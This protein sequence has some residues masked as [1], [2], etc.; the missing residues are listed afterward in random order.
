MKKKLAL[1]CCLLFAAVTLSSCA[2]MALMGVDLPGNDAM[3]AGLSN[4]GTPSGAGG[5]A[6]GGSG[7]TVTISR[8]EYDR[9]MKLQTVLDVMDI[10][11]TYYYEDVDEQAMIDGAAAGALAG[12]G[13]P[14]TFYYTAEEYA[15]LW[16]D[17]EGEYA[18][19]G[20]QITT[21]YVTNLCTISRVFAG[22]PAEKA[23]VQRND[24][25]YKVGDLFVNSET[26]DEA[27]SIMRGTPGTKVTVTFLRDGEEISFELERAKININRVS[28]MMLADG[29]GYIYLYEFAGECDKEFS[30]AVDQL[31]AEGAKGLIIDLRDNPGGWVSAAESI[32]DIFL[33]KGLVCTLRYKDG[34]EETYNTKDGRKDMA[35]VVLV[36]ENSASSSEILTGCLKDRAGATVVGKK[37]YGKGIVQ[38]VLPLSNGAGM[39]VT[40]AEYVTPNGTK[41]HKNGIEP[42]VEIGLE[43]GDN[44]MYDFGD[45]K[46]PQLAKALEVL[47]EKMAK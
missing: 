18:G 24:I 47:Q 15:E 23:G 45:L 32:C 22:S 37:S 12:I 13:D 8:A 44:G 26:I 28:S 39:Q 30:R 25:L 2:Y 35:L 1:L 9:L 14:Y 16:E 21:S 46:D 41:I 36:N 43:E 33:D 20:I 27:V 40:I 4:T 5:G 42:D 19:V 38:S 7:D 10:A 17:D 6:S 29:V 31:E 34:S 3:A 11:S